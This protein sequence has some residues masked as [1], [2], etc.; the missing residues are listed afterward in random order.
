MDMIFDLLQKGGFAVYV[1]LFLSLV[2]WALIIERLIN[3][4]AG[5][6]LSKS[7]KDVKSL[8]AG[9][10]IEGALKLLSLDNS[11]AGGILYRMLEEYKGGKVDKRTLLNDLSFE[12][13]LLVPK[14]EKNLALLSTIASVS[15]LIGLFGTITGLIKVFSAFAVA[16]TEQGIALLAAGISEAL[17]SAATGLA[18]AIPALLA[19][20]VFRIIGNSV[21]DRVEAEL[22]EALRVLK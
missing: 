16:Q 2:S 5:S 20:W 4:R 14:V 1:L 21:L 7:V 8:L 18:V 22:S 15:P 19:Y 3:L 6:I 17:V 12:V 13:S 10:D 9:G 11:P